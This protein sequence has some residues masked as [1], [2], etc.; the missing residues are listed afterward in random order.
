MRAESGDRP[1]W[2]DDDLAALIDDARRWARVGRHALTDPEAFLREVTGGLFGARAEGT[3]G[4]FEAAPWIVDGWKAMALRRLRCHRTLLDVEVRPRAE[5]ITCRLEVT[6]GPPIPL[7]LSLRNVPPVSHVTVDEVTLH[8][9]RA[10][11]TAAA[12]HEVVFFLGV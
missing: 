11:F 1:E 4:R 9:A 5:W 2:G 3:G 6:F 7:E 12:E 8:G 10:I